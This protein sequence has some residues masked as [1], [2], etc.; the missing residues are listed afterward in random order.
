MSVLSDLMILEAV[1]RTARAL[2]MVTGGLVVLDALGVLIGEQ[3]RPPHQ[4]RMNAAAWLIAGATAMCV[5]GWL[6]WSGYGVIG[7]D[8]PMDR[9]WLLAVMW[10]GMATAFTIRAA[11]RSFRPW[12]I[13]LLS[14]SLTIIMMVLALTDAVIA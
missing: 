1:L 9:Q 13:A 3:E 14:V 6:L 8:A 4:P 11:Y 7:A 2:A 10:L 12:T 5:A